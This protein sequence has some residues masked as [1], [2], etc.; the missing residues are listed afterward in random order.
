M[1]AMRSFLYINID[2]QPVAASFII[3]YRRDNQVHLFTPSANA[4]AIGYLVWT[5]KIHLSIHFYKSWKLQK[6]FPNAKVLLIQFHVNIVK[7]WLQW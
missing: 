4:I 6:Y 2:R 7:Q 3:K 1:T 5:K